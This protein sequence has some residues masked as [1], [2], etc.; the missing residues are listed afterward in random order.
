MKGEKSPDLSAAD[1]R[2]R[3]AS[4]VVGSSEGWQSWWCRFQFKPKGL[5]TRNAQE[6][7][8]S[9]PQLNSQAGEFP[10]ARDTISLFVLS[11]PAADCMRSTHSREGNLLYSGYWFNVDL[12]QNTLTEI[13][14]ITCDQISGHPVAQSRWHTKLIST[15]D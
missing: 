7:R 8:R 2:P 13:S 4:S 14:Q 15:L 10:L 5:R 1:W 12:I 9:R 11:R 6:R 3:K